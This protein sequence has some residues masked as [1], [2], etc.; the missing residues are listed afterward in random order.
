MYRKCLIILVLILSMLLSSIHIFSISVQYPEGGETYLLWYMEDIREYKNLSISVDG[1]IFR[2]N[3]SKNAWYSYPKI[4][5][6]INMSFIAALENI[7]TD[8][9]IRYAWYKD[10][11]TY[12]WIHQSPG[13]RE[14]RLRSTGSSINAYVKAFY[15]YW[16]KMEK[17]FYTISNN[18]RVLKFNVPKEN[19]YPYNLRVYI[20]WKGGCELISLKNPGGEEVL[21]TPEVSKGLN[22]IWNWH[23]VEIRLYALWYYGMKIDG[24]WTLIFREFDSN[25][26]MKYQYPDITVLLHDCIVETRDID[27]PPKSEKIV[28]I[29]E[30]FPPNLLET[31]HLFD[32]AH[33]I[34]NIIEGNINNVIVKSSLV[35]RGSRID[36]Y[37]YRK[38][39]IIKN[40]G[41]DGLKIRVTAYIHIATRLNSETKIVD[42]L[43]TVKFYVPPYSKISSWRTEKWYPD[44]AISISHPGF[45]HQI[46]VFSPENEI[47]QD[48]IDID[49]N[50]N[51]LITRRVL[52]RGDFIWFAIN[53][54]KGP[55]EGWWTYKA[56]VPKLVVLDLL[57]IVKLSDPLLTG[58]VNREGN[59]VWAYYSIGEPVYINISEN[60]KTNDSI[61]Y[62]FKGWIGDYYFG[63]KQ[64]IKLVFNDSII[65]YQ[66]YRFIIEYHL[67]VISKVGNVEGEGWYE[68]GSKVTISVSPTEMGFPIKYIFDHWSIDGQIFKESVVTISVDK[69]LTAIAYWREDYT[70]LYIIILLVVVIVFLAILVKRMRKK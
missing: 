57:K 42:N 33:F 11:Y 23:S 22:I 7:E 54:L 70:Q 8:G 15:Q 35:T 21:N 66:Q 65:I 4:Y 2:P 30:Y 49:F 46:A 29:K 55:F 39:F 56:Y 43:V 51:R 68:P 34:A 41:T 12:F 13:M 31:W 40:N 24:E 37:P 28:N 60:I 32:H 59:E 44:L 20:Y 10:G 1:V 52:P 25:T 63:P 18:N 47:I 26:P 36:F 64:F 45:W 58:K 3:L 62:V 38:E 17:I 16:L 67:K 9:I 61:R 6:K 69:P 14:I 27:I 53:T 5:V 48:Y 19:I 50:N